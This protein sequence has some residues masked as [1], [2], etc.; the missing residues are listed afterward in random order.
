MVTESLE[1][2]VEGYSSKTYGR[3]LGGIYLSAAVVFVVGMLLE[4]PAA[5]FVGFVGV[6]LI[7]VVADF[8]LQR[9]SVVL[10]DERHKDITRRASNSVFRIYGGGGFLVFV[11][12]MGL[13]FAGRYEMGATV[14]A[15]F[16]TWSA[17]VLTW[18]GFY[19]Y[20]KYRY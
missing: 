6:Y 1:G 4:R 12:L 11:S 10:Y 15:L 7:G 5:G 8:S 3:V 17:S 13:E 18:G 9:S 19:T 16:L 20:Y 14:E 2:V